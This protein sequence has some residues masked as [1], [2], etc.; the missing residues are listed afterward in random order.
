[1]DLKHLQKIIKI[2]K[3]N[4]DKEFVKKHLLEDSIFQLNCLLTEMSTE[5]QTKQKIA[6]NDIISKMAY[7]EY[8]SSFDARKN[9]IELEI[10]ARKS[11]I[12]T[13]NQQ[14]NELVKTMRSY[15]EQLSSY[16]KRKVPKEQY[17]LTNQ[18]AGSNLRK[19][20]NDNS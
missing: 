7:D 19:Q 17:K 2:T 13:A 11:A 9:A 1:M 4:L 20:A 15:E 8:Y 16:K 12:V 18:N 10:S 3:D 14:I 5:L 6:A